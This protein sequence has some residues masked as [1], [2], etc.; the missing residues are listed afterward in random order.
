MGAV[1][2]DSQGLPDML[3]RIFKGKNIALLFKNI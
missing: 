3:I 1:I 2:K